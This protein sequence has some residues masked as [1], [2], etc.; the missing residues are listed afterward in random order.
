M[1]VKIF[2]SALFIKY[3][4]NTD[5]KGIAC[6]KLQSLHPFIM[7]LNYRAMPCP[8]NF[9]LYL[10][11]YNHCHQYLLFFMTLLVASYL[12]LHCSWENTADIY[13]CVLWEYC[14]GHVNYYRFE[15]YVFI[16]LN[17]LHKIKHYLFKWINFNISNEN[18]FRVSI[19]YHLNCL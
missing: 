7:V 4:G 11:R 3:S 13:I 12:K 14:S 9:T 2:M 15:T 5:D 10:S 19:Y 18:V 6:T 16:R 1:E 17:L 8:A